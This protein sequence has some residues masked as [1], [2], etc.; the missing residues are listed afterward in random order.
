MIGDDIL[1]TTKI[2]KKVGIM[3]FEV[4]DKVIIYLLVCF[5]NGELTIESIDFLDDVSNLYA[6]NI[7]YL[8]CQFWNPNI[9]LCILSVPFDN[10]FFLEINLDFFAVY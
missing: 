7:V 10:L 2:Q 5:L 8:N 3:N 1:T 6:P 9:L 4:I